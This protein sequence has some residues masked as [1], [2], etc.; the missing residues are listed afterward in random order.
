[1]ILGILS[2][3]SILI[4]F[5]LFLLYI[6]VFNKIN[7]VYT[8]KIIVFIA[9]VLGLGA[10]FTVSAASSFSEEINTLLGFQSFS[11]EY[12][13]GKWGVNNEIFQEGGILMNLKR[14][15]MVLIY[16]SQALLIPNKTKLQDIEKF[17]YFLISFVLLIF[18]FESPFYRYGMVALLFILMIN[19]N[20]NLFSKKAFR[21]NAVIFT[22]IIYE[23][24]IFAYQVKIAGHTFIMSYKDFWSISGFS[25]IA[26]GIF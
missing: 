4:L 2:H 9:F 12:I 11:N 22:I 5:I 8:W 16:L 3:F 15:L 13:T 10:D 1:M 6:S 18:P 21:L 25:I 17:M 19:T 20:N 26:N 14:Y 24:F 23:V 7:K